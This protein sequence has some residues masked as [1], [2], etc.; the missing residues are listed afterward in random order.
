MQSLF[1]EHRRMLQA[2]GAAMAA[3]S[4]SYSVQDEK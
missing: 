3:H 2:E 1:E 4:R